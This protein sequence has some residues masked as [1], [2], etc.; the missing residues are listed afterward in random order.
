MSS[1]QK[2]QFEKYIK[3]TEMAYYTP[4]CEDL[5]STNRTLNTVSEPFFPKAFRI[6]HKN[7]F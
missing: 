7:N 1:A 6:L 4:I 5:G 2:K 3:N